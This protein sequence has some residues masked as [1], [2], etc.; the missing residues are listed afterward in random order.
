[1]LR[2]S[3]KLDEALRRTKKNEKN[4]GRPSDQNVFIVNEARW[5]TLLKD[6]RTK[7]IGIAPSGHPQP[8]RTWIESTRGRD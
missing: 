4:K 2:R 8:T 3:T 7:E 1:M 5:T 6:P